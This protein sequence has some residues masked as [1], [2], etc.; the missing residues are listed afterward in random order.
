M[1]ARFYTTREDKKIQCNLCPN[2]CLISPGKTGVCKVRLN[3]NGELIRPYFG[4]LAAVALDPIEKKP[5]Y[6]FYPGT[7]ILSIGFVGCSFHCPCCQNYHISQSTYAS[8]EF[9]DPQA[10]VELAERKRSFAIAY[11]YSEPLIHLEYVLE[12]ARIAR[13][14]GIKNVLVSNG[15]INPQPA[16]ELL[17]ILDA[18]NIDLKCFTEDFYRKEI[19]G[20]LEEVKRF[21][22]Q[23]AGKIELEV[24]T[25]V[26]PGKN[27][28]REE[29]AEIARFL[30]DLD[31]AIPYHLSC[32]YPTY[33]YTIPATPPQTVITLAEQARQYLKYV[34]VGNVGFYETNTMCP[35]CGS[36]LIERRGYAVAFPGVENGSCRQCGEKINIQG[37][38]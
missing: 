19:G 4:K 2:N 35:S 13:D 6:H 29:I 27:D 3:E 28:S 24:T 33:K 8:T 34:Y 5:L 30:A 38:P 12:A 32:Y 11:T 23:A 26:I 10:L 20:K 17:N 18:A 14:K 21:I 9:I 15:Y 22:T 31:P 1:K 16:E 37:L 25:L 36:T 7:S